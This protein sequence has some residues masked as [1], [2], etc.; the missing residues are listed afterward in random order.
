M[1]VLW[2]QLSCVY[3]ILSVCDTVNVHLLLP[4]TTV[5][6]KNKQQPKLRAQQEEWGGTTCGRLSALAA[7]WIRPGPDTSE[8]LLQ[9]I[10]SAF[11]VRSEFFNAL[12]D[13]STMQP[14]LTATKTGP[15]TPVLPRVTGA[16]VSVGQHTSDVPRKEHCAKLSL[17]GSSRPEH[18][19]HG[20]CRFHPFTF[21]S[22]PC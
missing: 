7:H 6:I 10:K 2:I 13:N 16:Q 12:S 14:G 19:K 8:L 5:S 3:K 11:W 4:A 15:T 9:P 18:G 21:P 1:F 22:P 17:K 20:T